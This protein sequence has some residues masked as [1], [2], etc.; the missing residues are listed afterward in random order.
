MCGRVTF[1]I[2]CVKRVGAWV[3]KLSVGVPR[4]ACAACLSGLRPHQCC[5]GLQAGCTSQLHNCDSLRNSNSL[6]SARTLWPHTKRAL[7]AAHKLP[8]V[9][10]AHTQPRY[11]KLE[12]EEEAPSQVGCRS[13]TSLLRSFST[14]RSDVWRGVLWSGVGSVVKSRHQKLHSGH[15][16]QGRKQDSSQMSAWL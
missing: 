3:C 6:I 5:R 13:K 15:H 2:S 9:N 16:G 12:Q 1:C 8:L 11:K 4:H 7:L 14:S 10:Q